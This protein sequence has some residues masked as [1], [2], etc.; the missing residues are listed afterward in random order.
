M[1]IPILPTSEFWEAKIISD[2]DQ[3]DKIF[4]FIPAGFEEKA[5]SKIMPSMNVRFEYILE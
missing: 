5:F 2:S 1:V 3:W 4:E